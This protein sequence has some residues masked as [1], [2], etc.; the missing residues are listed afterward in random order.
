MVKAFTAL[1]TTPP[2][3]VGKVFM[4]SINQYVLYTVYLFIGRFFLA[5]IAIVR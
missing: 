3:D 1:A 2:E 4:H 5:Y